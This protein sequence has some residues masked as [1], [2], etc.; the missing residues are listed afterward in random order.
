MDAL[1][2]AGYTERLEFN[3]SNQNSDKKKTRSR[4]I[5]WFKPPFSETVKTKVLKFD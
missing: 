5:I 2:Q 3:S 4:K 1:H